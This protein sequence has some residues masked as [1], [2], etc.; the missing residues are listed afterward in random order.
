MNDCQVLKSMWWSP[1]VRAFGPAG[2]ETE[3][4]KWLWRL[5]ALFWYLQPSIASGSISS[6]YSATSQRAHVD[7]VSSSCKHW[8][9]W[10]QGIISSRAWVGEG[11]GAPLLPSSLPPGL[12]SWSSRTSSWSSVSACVNIS[13]TPCPY[14][15][16]LQRTPASYPTEVTQVQI[17]HVNNFGLGRCQRCLNSDLP[18]TPTRSP[19]SHHSLLA[20]HVV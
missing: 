17:L 3:R 4:V 18:V 12:L 19:K 13:A 5:I 10:R 14:P 1:Q 2:R 16:S 8:G 11:E 6:A 7:E 15:K 20:S 9:K